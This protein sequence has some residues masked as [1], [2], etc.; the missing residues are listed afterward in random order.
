MH[1]MTLLFLAGLAAS[2]GLRLWLAQRQIEHVRA[3]REQ[4]P[5]EFSDRIDSA[6]HR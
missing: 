1:E 4:V 5:A 3:H 6:Q 2:T